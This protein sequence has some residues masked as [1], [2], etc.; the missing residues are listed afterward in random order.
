MPPPG[1]GIF[2]WLAGRAGIFLDVLFV[3]DFVAD[4]HTSSPDCW[5][6]YALEEGLRLLTPDVTVRVT[7][8]LKAIAAFMP[9]GGG[10]LPP[11]GEQLTLIVACRAPLPEGSSAKYPL[12]LMPST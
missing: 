5:E 8:S 11:Q 7:G 12:S 1:R 4:L 9:L 10:E 6:T 3:A 2:R